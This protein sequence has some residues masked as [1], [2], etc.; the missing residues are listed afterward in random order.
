MLC[1]LKTI[2]CCRAPLKTWI[3]YAS[4][5]SDPTKRY[6]RTPTLANDGSSKLRLTLCPLVLSI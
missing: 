2:C 3:L 6:A 1:I 4:D 5:A